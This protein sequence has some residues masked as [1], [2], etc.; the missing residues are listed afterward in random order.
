MAQTFTPL[1]VLAVLVEFLTE[2]LRE[3]IPPLQRFPAGWIAIVFGVSLCWLTDCGLLKFAGEYSRSPY[4]DYAITGL[5]VSRGSSV[6]HSLLNALKGY[7]RRVSV[8]V[9]PEQKQD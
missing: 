6:L 7:A 2:A 9:S 3:N 5:A 1:L 8:P 4:F